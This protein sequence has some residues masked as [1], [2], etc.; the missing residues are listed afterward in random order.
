MKETYYF[1]HDYNAR[2]D[3]K[4]IKLQRE[5]GLEAIAIYWYLIEMLYEAGGYLEL[6]FELLAFNM[7]LDSERIALAMRVIN[8]YN[9]FQIASNKFTNRR[10]I[11]TLKFKKS[12][13]QKARISANH[14]WKKDNANAM[15][16]QCEGN[17]IK[18]RKG[19]E[20]NIKQKVFNNQVISLK[21]GLKAKNYFKTWVNADD[22]SKRIN[23]AYYPELRNYDLC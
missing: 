17:A 15:R 13:S 8:D 7:R 20:I 11:D 4:L 2:N 5:C 1:P 6:N 23:V 12:K 10:V 9:L 18:E 3:E 16:T 19:K 14:R 21:D 22:T